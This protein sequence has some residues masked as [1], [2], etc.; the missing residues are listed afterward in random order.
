VPAGSAVIA[1][2]LHL[3]AYAALD[4]I[5]GNIAEE[6]PDATDR[7]RVDAVQFPTGTRL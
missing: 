4:D 1:Y 2:A 7:V 3:E 6:K 5:R